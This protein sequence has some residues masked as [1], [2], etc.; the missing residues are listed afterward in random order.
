MMGTI[1]TM[2]VSRARSLRV[3]ACLV[4]FLMLAP[5]RGAAEDE[6]Q[7]GAQVFQD[8]AAKGEIISVSPWYVVVNE[9]GSGIARVANPQYQYPFHFLLV[10]EQQPN[11]FAVPGGDV[12]ITLPLMTFVK[13]KEELAGVLCHETSHDIHHDVAHLQQKDQTTGL[14]ASG[15][16]LLLGGKSPLVANVIGVAAQLQSLSFSRQV[17]EA[18]DQ[19][20]A[21]TCAQAGYNPWGLVWLLQAFSKAEAGGQMEMLSDHPTNEHRIAALEAEFRSNPALFGR[22]SSSISS[23]HPMPAYRT[24]AARSPN[25]RP[26]WPVRRPGY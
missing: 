3:I 2:I 20:G 13:N 8:L 4:A 15:L 14:I 22:F 19:K 11:A 23:A 17:E 7:L 10:R 21:I 26:L 16:Q 12:Y 5:A 9:V 6:A 25:A 1:I 24:L 18:A